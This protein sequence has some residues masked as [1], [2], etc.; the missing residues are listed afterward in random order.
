MT[1][2]TASL[3]AFQFTVQAPRCPPQP[4]DDTPAMTPIM[5]PGLADLIAH[6][7][8][9]RSSAHA[10]TEEEKHNDVGALA[11]HRVGEMIQCDDIMD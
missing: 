10:W 6:F 5:D 3:H 2:V 7:A 8:K 1:R 11:A 4:R 9:E